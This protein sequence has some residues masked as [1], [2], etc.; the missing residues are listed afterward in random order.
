[1][2]CKAPTLSQSSVGALHRATN[3]QC[4]DSVVALSRREPKEVGKEPP[5]SRGRRVAPP[6]A[7]HWKLGC[8]NYREHCTKSYTN[9]GQT[10]TM[11]SICTNTVLHNDP[12]VAAQLCEV[13]IA[14]STVREADST[15]K[16]V[17]ASFHI[18]RCTK[19]EATRPNKSMLALA[20]HTA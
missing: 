11:S 17:R 18:T 16:R 14:T 7:Q 13:R 12:I 19:V 2:P 20:Q 1:M 6:G 8:T 4:T 10:C 3:M 9:K 5:A 15:R